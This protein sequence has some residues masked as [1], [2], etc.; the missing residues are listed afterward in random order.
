MNTTTLPNPVPPKRA[1]TPSPNQTKPEVPLAQRY[2]D[3]YKQVWA[4]MA[5]W[6]QLA[7]EDANK[8]GITNRFVEEFINEVTRE[9]E[10]S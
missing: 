8:Q 10:K 2:E 1:P 7:I 6:K 5:K 3:A 4:K 9:A